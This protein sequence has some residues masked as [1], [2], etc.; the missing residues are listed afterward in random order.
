MENLAYPRIHPSFFES[1][2]LAFT[3]NDTL[4]LPLGEKSADGFVRHCSIL[5]KCLLGECDTAGPSTR[6]ALHLS[7]LF[8]SCH[9]HKEQILTAEIRAAV[10][11]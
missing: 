1:P 8:L 3:Q 11:I 6:Y 4:H 7:F 5:P 2:V 10:R 9:H